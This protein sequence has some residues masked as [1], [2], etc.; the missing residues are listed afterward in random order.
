[1]GP[2]RQPLP[3]HLGTR[4]FSVATARA[5]GLTAKRLRGR[6][7]EAP[8][9]GVRVSAGALASVRDRC[10]AAAVWMRSDQ[11]FCHATTMQLL[12]LPLPA[13]LRT[14]HVHVASPRP[15]RAPRRAGVVGHSLDL[16][17]TTLIAQG[18]IRSV[19]PVDVWCQL[20]SQLTVRELVVLGDALVRRNDPWSTT[21]DLIRA[22]AAFRGRGR[23]RLRV[24][25]TMVRPRTDS[26]PE[27]ELRLDIVEAGLPEPEVNVPIRDDAGMLIGIADLAFVEQR[28]V[29]EYDGEQHRTDD[30]QYARDVDRLDDFAR[31]GYRVI[32]VNKHHRGPRRR[33]VL[34]RVREALLERGW[35]PAS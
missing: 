25:V 8:Y 14:D 10:L 7:L 4:P 16:S 6:D 30:R 23:S 33:A 15:H 18:V 28:V 27:T 24:A 26:A 32:R 31:A 29:V 9:R 1:M 5:E 19:H 21:A 22:V 3:V 34:A 35:V 11:V 2:P 13:R 12:D 20:A 17:R